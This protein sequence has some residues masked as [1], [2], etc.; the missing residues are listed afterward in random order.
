[1]AGVWGT[2]SLGFLALPSQAKSLATGSGGLV[3]R[4]WRSTS[5]ASRRSAWSRSARSRSRRRSSSSGVLK[6]TWGIRVEPEVETGG[7]DVS[8]ARMWGYPEFYIPVPGGYGTESHGHLGARTCCGPQRPARP[9][10]RL[11]RS[12]SLRAERRAPGGGGRKRSGSP[13]LLSFDPGRPRRQRMRRAQLVLDR[14]RVE[15]RA[16]RAARSCGTRGRRAPRPGA[17]RSRAAPASAASTPSSPTLRAHAAGPPSSRRGDVRA[18]RP[19]LRPLGHPAPEP[20]REARERTG[21]ADG[22]G[23]PDAEQDRVAVAV[24]AELDDGE[25]VPRRLALLPELAAATGSRTRPRRSRACGAAPPRPSRRASARGRRR[26]P[27]RS[28]AVRSGSVTPVSAIPP[29][30]ARASAPAAA[31]AARGRSTRQRRLGAGLERLGEVARHRRRRPTRS[32]APAPPARPRRSAR[33]RSRYASRR[34][35]STSA[36]SRRRPARPPPAPTRPRRAR[37]A[38]RPACVTT[39][40]P[41]ASIA[42]TTACAP[43]SLGERGQQRGSSTAARFSAT[44]SAPARSSARA[45][46]SSVDPAADRERDLELLGRALD[47]LEQ[48]PPALERAP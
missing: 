25:G 27:G 38:F 45:S 24:V 35:R 12:R 42:Q 31:R 4:R 43:N 23:R 36:G 8:R 3:L 6:V 14:R 22:A 7:L 5:S 16:R 48:R 39:S 33:G 26:R 1:M 21:V 15:A 30:S 2:L 47:Q 34:R 9:S 20:G 41:R 13:I 29:P 32:P 46:S 19:L 28:R 17:R 44:L 37:A 11:R 10:I 18:L 40:P